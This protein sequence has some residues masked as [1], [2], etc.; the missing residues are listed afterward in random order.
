MANKNT[1]KE[2]ESAHQ[3][4]AHL[5]GIAGKGMSGLA[6]MLKQKGYEISGS[7]EAFYDPVASLLKK[8]GIKF[9]EKH[10]PENI[11]KDAALIII[12]KHAGLTPEENSEV[13]A[14]FKSGIK[15]QSLPEALGDLTK[16]T[17]NTIV[18]GSF[19]KSTVTALLA[20]CLKNSAKE[21]RD[22]SYFIGAVPFGFSE[23]ARLGKSSQFILEG[24]EYPSSNWDATSKFLYLNPTNLILISAEHDHL[25]IFPTEKSYIKPYEK[26]I[27]LLPKNGLLVA[28]SYGKNVKSIT[29]RSKARV[30]E[31]GLTKS[32]LWHPEKIKYGAKTSFDVFRGKKKIVNLETTQLGNHNIENI[33]GVAAFVLEKNLLSIKELQKAVRSFGGLSGRLDLKTKKSAV[34]VYEGFGSSYSKARSIFEALSLH[35][36]NKKLITIFEPHTFSWRNKEAKKWYKDIFNTSETVIIL[37][38]PSHGAKTHDQMSFEEIVKEVKK[39]HQS[40]YGVKTEKEALEILKKVATKDNLIVLVSS[41]SLF[42]LTHSAPKLMEKLF[43]K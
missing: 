40:V 43:S 18:A 37:P 30:V 16:N 21:K 19:G 3:K 7:D 31:Y 28:S 41:G 6:I 1:S 20:W 33:V 17:E 10:S 26:L 22:P 35:Y 38:P 13:E 15:V 29:K 34:Q 32:S 4:R 25:N 5:I 9:K 39:N 24:D 23:N 14:A 2:N 27:S 8:N 11:P 42:G 36:P 12:G